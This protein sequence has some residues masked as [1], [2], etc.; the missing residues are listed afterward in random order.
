MTSIPSLN[1]NLNKK[2]DKLATD[3]NLINYISAKVGLLNNVLLIFFLFSIVAVR[4]FN[5]TK[6]LVHKKGMRK[7][8]QQKLLAS[9]VF[10]FLSL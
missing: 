4:K 8:Y 5:R 3:I 1:F 6:T 7:V 9:F 10:F 2:L